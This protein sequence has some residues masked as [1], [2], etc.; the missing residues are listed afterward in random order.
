MALASCQTQDEKDY[1]GQ[2]HFST[3]LPFLGVSVVDVIV[4][5]FQTIHTRIV[6]TLTHVQEYIYAYQ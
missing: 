4:H 6:Q 3:P 1:T 5:C 2:N